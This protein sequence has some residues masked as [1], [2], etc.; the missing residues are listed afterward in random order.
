[1]IFYLPFAVESPDR[2]LTNTEV[3]LGDFANTRIKE[4]RDSIA[5]PPLINSHDHLV[6]NWYP[7]AGHN[8]PYIN[9]HIWVEDMKDAASYRE[10]DKVWLNDGSF[11]LIEGNATILVNLGIYKNLFSG[12]GLVQD[13]AP[14]QIDQYYQNRPIEILK[15]Y[16]QCHSITLGNWWGGMKAEEEMAATG[17]T[18]PFII[19]VGE[20]LD[21]RTRGEFTLVRDRGLLKRNT[22]MIHCVSFTK[23]EI[24]QTGEAGAT[25]CWCPGS[26]EFLLGKTADIEECLERGVNVVIG[27]DS[28][29]SGTTNLFSE[30]RKAHE[31]L[32]SIPSK[33]LY[34][35]VT[36]NAAYALL[37]PLT[38]GRLNDLSGNLL[39]LDRKHED[40]F[41]NILLSNTENIR[42]FALN[43]RILYGDIEFMEVFNLN[44]NDYTV[45]K[46]GNREKFVLGNPAGILDTIQGYL[47]TRKTFPYLPIE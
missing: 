39:V 8:R 41:E 25:I 26:N 47:G 32:P 14:R 35:M 27:T 44:E 23:E 17:G 18:M 5:Y 29:M 43:N 28:T 38:Y 2:I 4:I 10:R 20:G 9:S 6:G 15:D 7:R 31:M 13:H 3:R 30:I 22:M 11:N 33:E 21:D 12:V 24:V 37:K 46:A 42:I 16:Y 40:P 34:R 19:H 45:F 36:V 1:M